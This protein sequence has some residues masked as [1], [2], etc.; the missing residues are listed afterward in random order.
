MLLPS[1]IFG[2][3]HC[4]GMCGPLVMMLGQ[5]RYRYWYFLGRTLSFTLAGTLAGS[6]G[7]VLNVFL[8]HYHISALTSIIFG[9]VILVAGLM[10][11]MRIPLPTPKFFHSIN[12]NLSLLLLRDHLFPTFLFGF[13]TV[14]LPCGQTLIV[15]SACALS[16][17]PLVGLF[18]GF[19]FAILTS[20]SLFFAM[21]ASQLFRKSR[22]HAN[23][24]IGLCAIVVG[25]LA[26]FRGL[27]DMDVIP[28][29]V[30]NHHYHI[31]LY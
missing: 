22:K 8:S 12:K 20:P 19:M 5:H 18:N 7:A 15:F 25:L 2:N 4:I 13:T 27:A 26:C 9:L 29:F 1:Y 31:V 11:L 23:T 14:F 16:G 10:A 6:L 17:S 24:M 3:L 30:L 21:Q 28:H